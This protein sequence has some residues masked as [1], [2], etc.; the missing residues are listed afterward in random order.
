MP[1]RVVLR[2]VLSFLPNIITWLISLLIIESDWADNENGTKK[3]N[4][5]SNKMLFL[6]CINIDEKKLVNFYF[7]IVIVFHI[8]E[9]IKY[10][11]KVGSY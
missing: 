11:G 9:E 8:V 1:S 7:I 6:P 3:Q 5:N 10:I 2:L 4:K